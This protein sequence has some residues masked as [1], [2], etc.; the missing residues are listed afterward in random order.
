[1][2]ENK[3]ILL[4]IIIVLT[5]PAIMFFGNMCMDASYG[6][7]CNFI[8]PVLMSIMTLSVIIH[9]YLGSG[10]GNEKRKNGGE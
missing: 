6:E 7:I 4:G 10:K 1:M 9:M 8:P 3:T 2:V 5:V